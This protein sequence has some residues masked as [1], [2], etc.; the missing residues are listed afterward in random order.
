MNTAADS[1]VSVVIPCLNRAHL[2]TPTIES[3][4]QQDYPRIEC[5]VVDG[6]STDGTVDMLR[7]YGDRIRWVS[8]PDRGHADAIN[9]GWRMSRGAVLAWLN[10][11][12]VYIVPDAIRLV[13][14]Y[15][16]QHPQVDLVYGDYGW[17]AE[18]GQVICDVVKPDEWNLVAAVKYCQHI[19]PQATAFMRRSILERVGWLDAEF[20]LGIDHE[21]WLRIGLV[22]TIQYSPIHIAYGRDCRGLSQRAD[23]G[24]AKVRV[25]EKFFRQ[26]NLPAPFDLPRFRRRALSNSYLV[27]GHYT[28]RSTRRAGLTLHYIAHALTTDPLNAPFIGAELL[29]WQRSALFARIPSAL[30]T[31]IRSAWRH[32]APEPV[33]PVRA[34][35]NRIASRAAGKG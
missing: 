23:M 34:E 12:D 24:A 35:H 15:L 17:I 6:G 31:K 21:L 3:V 30:R 29:R 8:E 27:G 1:L 11:D 2:L 28:W 7:Q 26:P 22:G 9:K 13:M 10:A 14:E 25:M 32:L 19:I 4:L 33:S 16:Q 5:I 18:D 20:A